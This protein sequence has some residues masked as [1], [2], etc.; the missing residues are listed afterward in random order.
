MS[1]N[2]KFNWKEENLDLYCPCCGTQLYETGNKC[3]NSHDT[4]Q[5]KNNVLSF[6]CPKLEKCVRITVETVDLNTERGT[7]P[8]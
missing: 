3:T 8:F 6:G 4:I 7:K 2:V 5:T 1:R